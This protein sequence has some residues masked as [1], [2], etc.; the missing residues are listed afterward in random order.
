MPAMARFSAQGSDTAT[1]ALPTHNAPSGKRLNGLVAFPGFTFASISESD[2][3]FNITNGS[4]GAL[5]GGGRKSEYT[6]SYTIPAAEYISLE[7]K[8]LLSN[9]R[10]YRKNLGAEQLEDIQQLAAVLGETQEKDDPGIGVMFLYEVFY[11]RS[12]D[13]TIISND[14]SA[15]KGSAVL[16][17]MIELS[18]RKRALQSKL[19]A[20]GDIAPPSDSGGNVQA[21]GG[22]SKVEVSNKQNSNTSNRDQLQQE[23]D[24]IQ[25]E[26]AA[27]SRA[28]IPNAPGVTG[29]ITRSSINGV[30]LT[31]NF[32]YPIAIG[33]RAL[34]YDVKNFTDKKVKA[35][36]KLKEAVYLDHK[37]K[38]DIPVPE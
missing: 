10:D 20:V 19:L 1:W 31:Q 27:L 28:T 35:E 34:T 6:V 25:N 29:S 3:G 18:E 24:L 4:W 14:A 26:I 2:L 37:F 11:A 22:S 38:I 13:V 30:T 9:I 17:S 8:T 15:I 32:Y 16:A 12:I 7:L 36:P 33:F 21:Q 23:L 5:F